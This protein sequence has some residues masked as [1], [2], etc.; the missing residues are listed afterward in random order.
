MASPET[1]SPIVEQ[2]KVSDTNASEIK[3]DPAPIASPPDQDPSSTRAAPAVK[4]TQTK[5]PGTKKTPPPGYKFVKVRYPDGSIRTVQRKKS[6][7]E[8]SADESKAAAVNEAETTESS[9]SV[10]AISPTT[11]QAVTAPPT[12]EK[13]P[14]ATT[15]SPGRTVAKE[16]TSPAKVSDARSPTS[17]VSPT[18]AA[19]LEAALEAQT[20]RNAKKRTSRFR[21]QLIRGFAS[22]IGAVVPTVELGELHHGDEVVDGVDT[23]SDYD[24]DDDAGDHDH[25]ENNTQNDSHHENSEIKLHTGVAAQTAANALTARSAAKEETK[26]PPAANGDA[27]S[28]AKG[29]ADKVTYIQSVKELEEAEKQNLENAHRPLHRHWANA[30]FYIMASMSILL[31][32][33]FLS[34]S[35]MLFS[36]LGNEEANANDIYSSWNHFD[37]YARQTS[38]LPL[39]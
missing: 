34:E 23:D 6:P 18:D 39:E 33:M 22:T 11:A 4:P 3:P 16:P 21:S 17:P 20:K 36:L 12:D 31:P 37:S 14:D 9:G 7:E 32:L 28:K 29:P 1:K 10:T 38:K 35:E 8:L 26:T 24:M 30:S 19:E 5:K 2:A 27:K 13:K 25:E 15:I